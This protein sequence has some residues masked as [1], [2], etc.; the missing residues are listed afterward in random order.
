MVSDAARPTRGWS[1]G[2]V[3][4]PG[5]E[6]EMVLGREGEGVVALPA[7]SVSRR[8]ARAGVEA[9]RAPAA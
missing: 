2:V 7:A 8:H 1:S 9:G 6:G 4:Y 5:Y 3:A